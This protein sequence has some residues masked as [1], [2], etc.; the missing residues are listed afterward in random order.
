M[1]PWK[2]YRSRGSF[3]TRDLAPPDLARGME[4]DRAR[5]LA[6]VL[7]D[8]STW[9]IARTLQRHLR[10]RDGEGL[11]GVF[12][13]APDGPGRLL[14][15]IA[16][17][18]SHAQGRRMI[19]SDLRGDV[20]LEV[21][22]NVGTDGTIYPCWSRF[23]DDDGTLSESFLAHPTI[24]PLMEGS[25]T[26]NGKQIVLGREGRGIRLLSAPAPDLD[27]DE[28][29]ARASAADWARLVDEADAWSRTRSVRTADGVALP[30]RRAIRLYRRWLD[31]QWHGY[32]APL[33]TIVDDAVVA[34]WR[35]TDHYLRVTFDEDDV[36]V[37]E[38]DGGRLREE[39]AAG[40]DTE[41]RLRRNAPSLPLHRFPPQ[42]KRT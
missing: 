40:L 2:P 23:D 32:A 13:P 33:V 10:G 24:G 12:V 17:T 4:R 14:W 3:T 5:F 41:A 30:D 20:M 42:G 27:L 18:A 34:E 11:R 15:W 28:I 16:G 37:R 39:L 1:R 9:E 25:I 29:E 31:G 22:M 26:R 19:P 36:R 6:G 38:I 21:E 7:I 35:A 8:P